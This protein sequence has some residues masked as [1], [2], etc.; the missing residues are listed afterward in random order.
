[1]SVL[2]PFSLLNALFKI[3]LYA[4]GQ[5]EAFVLL[6]PGNPVLTIYVELKQWGGFVPAIHINSHLTQWPWSCKDL[7][8][9][10]NSSTWIILDGAPHWSCFSLKL[11]C[12]WVFAG[13][14][15]WDKSFPV[16]CP[17]NSSGWSLAI[18]KGIWQCS[19]IA[20]TVLTR[21]LDFCLF[22]WVQHFGRCVNHSLIFGAPYLK[23]KSLKKPDFNCFLP[24]QVLEFGLSCSSLYNK[25]SLLSEC[26]LHLLLLQQECLQARKIWLVFWSQISLFSLV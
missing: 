7:S 16:W 21:L 18:I 2:V 15:S 5:L 8:V 19:V 26:L 10:L 17:A 24:C 9:L 1:M 4:E 12:F 14:G 25:Q 20:L 11:N 6:V 23:T 13:S 3:H 22:D